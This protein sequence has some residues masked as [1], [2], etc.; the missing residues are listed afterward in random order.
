LAQAAGASASSRPIATIGNDLARTGTASF[1]DRSVP[2]S[3]L[4]RRH[5]RP[6]A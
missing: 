3:V 5:G 6:I 4:D 2:S 1:V